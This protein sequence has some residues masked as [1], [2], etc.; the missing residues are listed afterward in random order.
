MDTSSLF[1]KLTSDVPVSGGIARVPE[2]PGVGF[3]RMLV[4]SEV[5]GSL[6]H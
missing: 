1:G 5:F 3:E 2:A 6:L 4:F